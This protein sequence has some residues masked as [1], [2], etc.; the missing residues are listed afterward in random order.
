[1]PQFLQ[2]KYLLLTHNSRTIMSVKSSADIDTLPQKLKDLIVDISRISDEVE[3]RHYGYHFLRTS[4]PRVM[5]LRRACS[6]LRLHQHHFLFIISIMY[7]Q[8]SR[9]HLVTAQWIFPLLRKRSIRKD[10]ILG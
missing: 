1:M 4:F 7:L 6:R 3:R 8:P 10:V 2:V 5:K 9:V